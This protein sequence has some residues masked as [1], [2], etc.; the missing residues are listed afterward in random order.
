MSSKEIIKKHNSKK[1]SK[2]KSLNK[3]KVLIKQ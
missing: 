1:A 2:N 3:I